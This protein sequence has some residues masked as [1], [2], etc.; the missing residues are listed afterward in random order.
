[1]AVMPFLVPTAPVRCGVVGFLRSK[2]AV[3]VDPRIGS[4]W[5]RLKR[6]CLGG[7]LIDLII[8]LKLN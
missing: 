8:R 2:A 6:D 4:P 5:P 7:S 3:W 1:M